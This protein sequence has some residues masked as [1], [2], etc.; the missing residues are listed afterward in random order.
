[1]ASPPA[2]G[3]DQRFERPNAY[4]PN[5]IQRP[6]GDSAGI[7]TSSESD[8]H[9]FV[10]NF[11]SGCV[12]RCARPDAAVTASSIVARRNMER[13]ILIYLGRGTAAPHR[14]GE[15]IG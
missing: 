12:A 13:L 2:A 1:M 8:C 10:K 4:V 5:T 14:N 9:T 15:T 6:S 11:G 7:E 3:I